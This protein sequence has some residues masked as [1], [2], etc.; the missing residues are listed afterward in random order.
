MV[1]DLSSMNEALGLISIDE[2]GRER[3]K[4]KEENKRAKHNAWHLS[5]VANNIVT[6]VNTIMESPGRN[7]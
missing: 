1:E 6:V 4:E 2:G 3:G 7:V 5:L